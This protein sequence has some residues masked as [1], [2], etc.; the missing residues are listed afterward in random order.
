MISLLDDGAISFANSTTNAMRGTSDLSAA[1]FDSVTGLAGLDAGN[2]QQVVYSTGG[3]AE[4]AVGVGAQVEA[5]IAATDGTDSA[6][7]YD[8]D[9]SD[10]AGR[11]LITTIDGLSSAMTVSDFDVY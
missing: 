11:E 1:D 5:Y 7:Y 9:W 8:D 4:L 2:D 10:V 6:L 3:A